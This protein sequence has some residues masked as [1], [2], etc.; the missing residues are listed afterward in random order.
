MTVRT[1]KF[2]QICQHHREY[3]SFKS[4]SAAPIIFFILF[5]IYWIRISPSDG[6]DD[7][8]FNITVVGV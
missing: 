2:T 8:L 5:I 4:F 1:L 3:E 6:K 7:Q